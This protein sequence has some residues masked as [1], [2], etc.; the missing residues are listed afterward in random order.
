MPYIKQEDRAKIDHYAMDRLSEEIQKGGPGVA[1][2][3][4]S[5]IL[6]KAYDIQDAPSYKKYN[7]VM[8][9]LSAAQAELARRF[10]PYEQKKLEENGDI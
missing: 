10:G 2:F 8:G 4:I 6:W 5:R 3:I 7:E 1:N 9:V